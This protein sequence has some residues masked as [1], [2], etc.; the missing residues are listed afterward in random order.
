MILG[1]PLGPKPHAPS[2]L[3]S[4][5][6]GW[7][8][9]TE[10]STPN[11]RS[12]LSSRI[13]WASP[14]SRPARAAPF[15]RTS[16]KRSWSR[17]AEA[18]GLSK[19]ALIRACL[20]ISG[21]FDPTLLSPGDTVTNRALQAMIDGLTQRIEG[22]RDRVETV[23]DVL[24]EDDG[25]EFDPVNVKDTRRRGVTERAVREGQNRFRTAVLDA[26]GRACAL[27]GANAVGALEAAHV[28]PYSGTISN[29]VTNGICLRADLHRL[30][31]SGQIALDEESG[32]V[33][34]GAA[35][36][37]TTY[38]SLHGSPAANL[39]RK[40][41]ERPSQLALRAHREWCGLV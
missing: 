4:S 13:C 31:D 14:T 33:L 17:R 2:R 35:L 36:R 1:T 6:R 15:V 40:R 18:I 38:A 27:T 9:N 22:D 29:V 21:G 19:D 5:L 16:S 25:L 23:V 37:T 12:W 39:P 8:G 34:L 41:S 10:S 7:L 30:W 11:V 32:T 28:T 20:E 24:W 26:Y 3:S